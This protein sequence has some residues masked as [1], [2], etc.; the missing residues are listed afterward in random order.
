MGL[1]ELY[2]QRKR[3]A[4]RPPTLLIGKRAAAGVL[5]SEKKQVWDAL[6][7]QGRAFVGRSQGFRL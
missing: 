1:G 5:E 3:D 2:R 7:R 6:G 4:P